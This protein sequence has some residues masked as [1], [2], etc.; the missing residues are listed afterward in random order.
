M[1][2]FSADFFVYLIP[3]QNTQLKFVFLPRISEAEDTMKELRNWDLWG[4]LLLCMALSL[5]LSAASKQSSTVF[6]LV[7]VLVWGGASIVTANCQVNSNL[8]SILNI[9]QY[10]LRAKYGKKKTR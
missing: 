6:S 7:F 3:C 9:F 1:W 8:G 5:M 4:P 10:E 2:C